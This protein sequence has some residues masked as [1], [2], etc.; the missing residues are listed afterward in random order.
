MGA[1][2]WYLRRENRWRGTKSTSGDSVRN[3]EIVAF[4][5]VLEASFCKPGNVCP[6][7]SRSFNYFEL[8]DELISI[9]EACRSS[10]TLGKRLWKMIRSQKKSVLTGYIIL[11][12]PLTFADPWEVSNVLKS[13]TNDDV[14]AFLE[15][16][17][18][19]RLSHIKKIISNTYP[20]FE[21][22][23][24]FQNLYELFSELAKYDELFREVIRGY[25]NALSV[26]FFL[27][28]CGINEGCINE[29]QRSLLVNINDELIARKYG[30]GFLKRIKMA[31][32]Y[33]LHG[34]LIELKNVN[35]GTVADVIATSLYLFLKRRRR[36]DD[37][38]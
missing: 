3:C 34:D 16:L 2:R 27:E 23:I 35:P 24:R 28:E 4:A 37:F 9:E 19:L 11:V 25:P 26:S 1:N 31:A 14:R 12:T 36:T 29:V 18:E 8:I 32:R 21:S 30:Y 20:T 7:R 22:A 5:A 10:S 38:G 13:T 15:S 33:G 17:K 6:T